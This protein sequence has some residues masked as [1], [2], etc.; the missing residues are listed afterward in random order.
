VRCI[1][2]FRLL[3]DSA[4]GGGLMALFTRI[5]YGI[6]ALAACTRGTFPRR[7]S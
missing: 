6:V 3:S 4:G 2:A 7:T 1:Y 5:G